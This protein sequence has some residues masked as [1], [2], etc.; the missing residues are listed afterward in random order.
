M[1]EYFI[2][3]LHQVLA[4]APTSRSSGSS[5][6]SP[7]QKVRSL[8]EI[9]E[10]CSFALYVTEPTFFE[11]AI[12]NEDWEAAEMEEMAAIEHNHTWELVDL[13]E[14]KIPIGL[15]WVYKVK[16]HADESVQKFKARL[17]AKGYAQHQGIDFDETFSPVAR[18]ETVRVLLSLGAKLNLPIYQFDVM[19]A[20]LNGEL[21]EEVYV[22]HPKGFAVI[23]HENK[24]YKLRKALYGLK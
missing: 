21:E 12:E 19:S 5:S 2:F 1:C 3:P 15:K 23:G 18:F 17:V 10:S 14:D 6:Q 7:P 24:V 8:R 11:E 4:A 16:H 22:F 20:F 9:Y 13:P